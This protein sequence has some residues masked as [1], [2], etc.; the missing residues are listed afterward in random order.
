MSQQSAIVHNPLELAVD[1]STR[2]AAELAG[3]PYAM[4][5]RWDRA[6]IITST[7]PAAG[8]GSRRRWSS[9]DVDH[10]CR[11]AAVWRDARSAGVLLTWQAV[12]G[13]W[14]TLEAG[15]TWQLTLTA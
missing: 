4:V 12:A 6:R 8:Y 1:Y 9:G 14:Q 10:L 3:L 7:V 13:I 11:I 5:D 15:G 2:E